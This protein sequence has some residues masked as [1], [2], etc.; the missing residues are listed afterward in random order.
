MAAAVARARSI[1]FL[2]AITCQ[3]LGW[4]I[5]VSMILLGMQNLRGTESVTA[6][7][8]NCDLLAR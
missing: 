6:M 8:L 7:F 5:S 2:G 3:T 4:F 1:R